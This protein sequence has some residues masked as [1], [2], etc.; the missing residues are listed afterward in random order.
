MSLYALGEDVAPDRLRDVLEFCCLTQGRSSDPMSGEEKGKIIHQD[1]SP[2]NTR[3]ELSYRF[4]ATDTTPFM[5]AGFGEYVRLTGDTDFV[6]LH[7]AE[8]EQAYGWIKRHLKYGLVW[9]D[10][11][12]YG[13]TQSAALAGYFR[14]G[15]F[16][17]IPGHHLEYPA[18]Y[19]NVNALTVSGIRSLAALKRQNLLP[20]LPKATELDTEAKMIAEA[21]AEKLWLPDKGT[22][23]AAMH[24]GG[25]V[26]QTRYADPIWSSYFLDENDFSKSK[27]GSMF[28]S[29]ES[30]TTPWGVAN[31]EPIIGYEEYD[32]QNKAPVEQVIWPI[33]TAFSMMLAEKHGRHDIAT[34][35]IGL[36]DFLSSQTVPFKEAIPI[37]ENRPMLFGC[38][39]QLWTVATMAR[40]LQLKRQSVVS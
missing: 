16:H 13:A 22:L 30:L 23:G 24:G 2:L 3:N 15:G 10:P 6:K 35:S 31:H 25:K 40:C 17:E 37:V 5:L 34:K 21:L 26:L 19:A 11:A 29:L 20:Q 32:T 18:T 39:L 8:I 36:Y 14:D 1:P 27:W 9:D 28:E 33:E 7:E 4:S 38:D 12:A